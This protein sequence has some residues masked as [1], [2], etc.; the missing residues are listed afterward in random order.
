[1]V[2]VPLLTGFL[3]GSSTCPRSYPGYDLGDDIPAQNIT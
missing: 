3:A 2:P 1:V